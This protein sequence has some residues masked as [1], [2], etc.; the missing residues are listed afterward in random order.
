MVMGEACHSTDP[1]SIPVIWVIFLFQL[2]I[3]YVTFVLIQIDRTFI[4]YI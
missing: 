1:G 4:F 2:S 3:A